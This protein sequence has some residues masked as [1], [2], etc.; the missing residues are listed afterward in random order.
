MEQMMA[1]ARLAGRFIDF[2]ALP[3]CWAG[4]VRASSVG[5]R[6]HAP[7]ATLIRRLPMMM[8]I[9][10]ELGRLSPICALFSFA[11]AR[12]HTQLHGRSLLMQLAAVSRF[13]RA[14]CCSRGLGCF[15]SKRATVLTRQKCDL[16]PDEKGT[17]LAANASLMIRERAPRVNSK[18]SIVRL[19][20]AA[21]NK[22]AGQSD[23]ISHAQRADLNSKRQPLRPKRQRPAKSSQL[24]SFNLGA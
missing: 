15:F 1:T 20:A 12:S 8:I 13:G 19:L 23:K 7:A 18:R 11:K 22:Q 17:T 21:A 3:P 6:R 4:L 2:L 10:N 16:R 9:I 5:M 14:Y 24:N